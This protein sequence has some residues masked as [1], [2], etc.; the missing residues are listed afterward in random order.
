MG[1]TS[2]A[3][4]DACVEMGFISRSRYEHCLGIGFTKKEDYDECFRL[5]FDDRLEFEESKDLGLT[6]KEAYVAWREARVRQQKLENSRRDLE[7]QRAAAIAS[8]V[9]MRV[10]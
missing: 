3:D 7:K 8:A 1:F 10:F 6:S 4:H 5:G 2:K 9:I